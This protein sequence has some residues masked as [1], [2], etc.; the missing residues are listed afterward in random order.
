MS[1]AAE[2]A[3]LIANVN[4]GSSLGSKNFII[5]GNMSV[6][7][8]SASA[9][10]VSGAA[11]HSVDR[12]KT[13]HD[14]DGAFTVEQSTAVPDG[15]TKS[16]KAQV[17]TADGTI[18]S[19]QYASISQLIEGQNMQ[20]FAYGTS[21]AKTITL[22]FHVRSSKTGSYSITLYKGARTG[23]S[24]YLFNKSYT[25]DSANTWEKKTI[26]IA[27]DS[28]IKASAGA[29]GNDN[30]IGFYLF[31][32]LSGGSNQAG[33]TDNTWSSNTSHYHTS[34]QVNWMDS[35]SNDFYITGVQMEIGEK[36]TEFEHEPFSESL[37]KCQRYYFRMEGDDI[38]GGKY[39]THY[40]KRSASGYMYSDTSALGHFYFPV[41][42]RIAPTALEQN[43]TDSDYDFAY[44]NTSSTPSGSVIAFN[45]ATQYYCTTLQGGHS[46][47]NAQGEYGNQR[48]RQ[49]AG[50]LAWSA[51]L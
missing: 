12:F 32:N 15:F 13:W 48:I 28:Q 25:I 9:V 34:S 46:D 41:P 42:M 16:L 27:P 19:A 3:A 43:G 50:Y 20:S 22:S 40:R 18:G 44:R 6:S 4:K 29:L 33:A 47:N 30:A 23:T 39:S 35:T 14:T 8:R 17:T 5:N 10:A 7:Q 21:S 24:S 2:L 51:E 26:T 38:D 36:A 1:K 11:Y 31:W 45:D 37:K 49:S